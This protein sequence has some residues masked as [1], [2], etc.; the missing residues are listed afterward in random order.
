MMTEVWWAIQ[1]V[2]RVRLRSPQTSYLW[3]LTRRWRIYGSEKPLEE[4]LKRICVVR[5]ERGGENASDG[6]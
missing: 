4:E 3:L 5:S 1:G 6:N 2:R